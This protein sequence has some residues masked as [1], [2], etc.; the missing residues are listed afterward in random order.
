M[1]TSV[2]PI[3]VKINNSLCRLILCLIFFVLNGCQVE[4]SVRPVAFQTP[5]LLR[6]IPA[7][8]L[9]VTV[10]IGSQT[11]P[12]QG[13]QRDDGA[14]EVSIIV[15]LD[16]EHTASVSWYGLYEREAVLI[17]KQ[18]G[19]FYASSSTGQANLT[20]PMITSGTREFDIDCDGISNYEELSASGDP[21]DGVC[22]VDNSGDNLKDDEPS[23]SKQVPDLSEI[24]IPTTVPID[25]GC[26]NIGSPLTE[27]NRLEWEAQ[28]YICIE[29]QLNV[30][31]YEVTFDQY[32]YFADQPE[33]IESLPFDN[34]GESGDK[35]VK[36]I[37][38][39]QA[40]SYTQWLSR[41]TGKNYRLLTEAEWEYVARGNTTTPYWTGE[42]ISGS[43]ENI[44]SDRIISV[45]SLNQPNPF[46]LHD[47]LGNVH[48]WTCTSFQA[49]YDGVNENTCNPS[50]LETKVLRGGSFYAGASF[51][52][53]ASRI[54][55][56]PNL[57]DGGVGFRVVMVE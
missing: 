46:G 34:G 41:V 10:L 42:I 32:Y 56:N 57:V 39:E 24:P 11:T 53:S 37:I 8:N 12:Y 36:N 1:E 16:R 23:N 43:Y 14:W 30:G 28:Q 20:G 18:T 49:E 52:R 22:P 15:E 55:A 45:G 54:D 19:T 31:V 51:S 6:V 40:M 38:W 29:Q 47:M 21:S 25:P 44:N 4:E 2:S 7:E 26:F 27:E 48:E 33:N 9:S 35:P 5:N 50:P 13:R 17:A 3:V